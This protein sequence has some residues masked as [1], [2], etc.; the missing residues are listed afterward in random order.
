MDKFML[1][2]SKRHPWFYSLFRLKALMKD[3]HGLRIREYGYISDLYV[4]STMRKHGV[5]AAL[6]MRRHHFL[7]LDLL[8]GVVGVGL[9]PADLASST[10]SWTSTVWHEIFV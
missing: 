6:L 5:A 10:G 9:L 4:V 8:G 7:V 2:E 3:L 1:Q